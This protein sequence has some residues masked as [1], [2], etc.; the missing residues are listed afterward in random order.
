MAFETHSSP[1]SI[2][3][4]TASIVLAL[5]LFPVFS[6]LSLAGDLNNDSSLSLQNLSHVQ[7]SYEFL[8]RLP[9]LMKILPQFGKK[10][11]LCG[12]Y[13]I[14]K[15]AQLSICV[16]LLNAQRIR[17]GESL[18]QFIMYFAILL[19]KNKLKF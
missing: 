7:L 9:N 8:C 18:G 16:A 19:L 6:D 11:H 10:P 15:T 17:K 1:V 2:W 12:P 5:A 13:Y 4:K 14:I 3:G